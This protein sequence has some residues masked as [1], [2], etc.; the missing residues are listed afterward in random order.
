MELPEAIGVFYWESMNKAV[1]FLHHFE[2]YE[3]AA[4]THCSD[5]S[6]VCFLSCIQRKMDSTF[7][8]E[9]PEGVD[10]QDLSS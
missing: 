8:R 4:D 5:H 9:K 6:F 7:Q 2:L 3:E 10:S 1:T